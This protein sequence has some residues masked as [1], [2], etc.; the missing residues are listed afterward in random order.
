M[1]L[2]WTDARLDAEGG[3]VI[4]TPAGICARVQGAPAISPA[5]APL[6]R[7]VVWFGADF[8]LLEFEDTQPS[9]TMLAWFVSP[10]G[11]WLGSWGGEA[12][13]PRHAAQAPILVSSLAPVLRK[14]CVQIDAAV[15]CPEVRAFLRMR[16]RWRQVLSELAGPAFQPAIQRRLWHNSEG[17]SWPAAADARLGSITLDRLRLIFYGDPLV[18]V[19]DALASGRFAM[20]ALSHDGPAAAVRPIQT[21]TDWCALQVSD[22]QPGADWI[23]IFSAALTSYYV[24]GVVVPQADTILFR[25][26]H[27]VG[28]VAPALVRMQRSLVTAGLALAGWNATAQGSAVATRSVNRNHIGHLAWNVYPGIETALALSR[29]GPP[30]GLVIHDL[31]GASDDTPYGPLAQIF[32][33][34][35]G[36]VR[37]TEQTLQDAFAVAV[38]DGRHLLPVLGASIPLSVR[39]RLLSAVAADSGARAAVRLARPSRLPG[40][41]RCPT[42][43]LGIRLQN[44][45]MPDLLGFYVRLVERLQ[46]ATGDG[47]FTVILDGMNVSRMGRA[48]RLSDSLDTQALLEK[49]YAFVEAL[50]AALAGR[51][52]HVVS[53]VGTDLVTNIALL[54]GGDF[55]VAPNG[56]GLVKLRWVHRLPGF[57][58]TSAQ[59]LR[60]GD[61]VDCYGKHVE[62]EE[63]A[64]A[65]LGYTASDEVEDLHPEGETFDERGRAGSG[66]RGGMNIVNFRLREEAAVITRIE[67]MFLEALQRS[68]EV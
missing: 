22:G 21:D 58:L 7:G 56:A 6:P 20:P 65:P 67:A 40:G 55:F 37:L 46:K 4:V 43:I 17:L 47:L 68:N 9:A 32:P 31:A 13:P 50:E 44:R 8:G 19:H 66:W 52:I 42:L 12:L 36:R 29:A 60:F 41:S 14:L 38:A 27:L 24:V 30:K 11:E 64:P 5:F 53:C 61:L 48:A 63:E 10:S 54:R 51:A 33:E 18:A 35:R 39:R 28:Y 2:L 57:V 34:L 49:E 26:P 25:H 62:V 15:R 59:S 1:A 3:V 23:C 16:L 45:T